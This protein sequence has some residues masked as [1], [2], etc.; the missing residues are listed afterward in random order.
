MQINLVA[1]GTRMPAW[2]N[3]GYQ[4][5]ARRLPRECALKLTEIPLARRARATPVA[6]AVDEEGKH[7]LAAVAPRQLAV[8]LDVKGRAWST[9]Q[10]AG[11]LQGWLQDGRNVSLLVGG[12]DGLA[13]ACL[14][15]AEQRWSLSTLTLPHPLVRVLLAE[16]LYR[17]WTILN[18]HPYHRS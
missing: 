12:P 2:V 7:M 13:P 3:E 8:A 10:L 5:Y 18:N 15:R 6:R 4:E 1:V 14:E 16:Q 9:E 11:Q 17:A